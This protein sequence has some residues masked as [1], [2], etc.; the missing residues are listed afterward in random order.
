MLRSIGH[1]KVFVLDGGFALAKQIGVEMESGNGIKLPVSSYNASEWNWPATTID[2]VEMALSS[3]KKIIID[4]RGEARYRGEVEPIDTIAGHIPGAVN[5]PFVNNL[6]K[7]GSYKLDE[8]LKEI[9]AAVLGGRE[10]TEVVFHCGS[11]VT[12]CHSIL[13]VAIAGFEIPSLYVGSWSEWS[14]NNKPMTTL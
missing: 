4:V 7:D 14:R 6:N 5:M 13:A 2:E 12:A 3:S 11:G 10:A 8:E 9:Y 1:E